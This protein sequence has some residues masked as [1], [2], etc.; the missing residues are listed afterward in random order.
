[1]PDAD[2]AQLKFVVSHKQVFASYTVG[3]RPWLD[4]GEQ[5]TDDAREL[6]G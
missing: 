1:M 4:A 5:S 3:Q 6:Q 2:R